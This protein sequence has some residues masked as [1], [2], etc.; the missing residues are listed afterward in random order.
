MQT[1][2]FNLND[3]PLLL[4]LFECAMLATLLLVTNHGKFLSNLF[5]ALFLIAVGLDSLDTLIYWSPYIKS[6]FLTH[7]VHIFFVLKFS[8]Y[9]KAP[10]LFLYTRSVVYS[11]YK[12]S[13]KEAFHLLPLTLSPLYLA[14]LYHSLGDAQVYQATRDYQV[15]FSN[16]FFQGHLWASNLV[17]VFYSV[18]SYRLWASYNEYLQQNYSS[19]DKID[20]SWLRLLILG[21]VA[22]WGWNFAGYVLHLMMESIWLPDTM[23]IIGNYFNFIFINALVFYSLIH[24]NVFQGVQSEVEQK[25]NIDPEAIDPNHVAILTRAMEENKIFLDAE[26]TLEQLAERVELPVRQVSNIINRHFKKNFYEYVNYYRVE[27]AKALLLQADQQA[28]ML[29]V[30]ADAGFNSKS[31]FNRYFKKFV[32]MTPTEFRDSKLAKTET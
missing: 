8:V 7:S 23:G 14:L 9:L 28:S 30:M 1:A 4:V 21:F 19:I 31:A 2:V 32:N 10:M 22:I 26:I 5:M 25:R 13:W 3:I 16:P 20:H 6:V 27:Q 29:D 24:S 15:L 17:Y 12:F 11:D 18:M